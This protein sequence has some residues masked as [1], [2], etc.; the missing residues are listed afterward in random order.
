MGVTAIVDAEDYDRLMEHS[1]WAH[2]TKGKFYAKTEIARRV[3][4]MHR[5]ILGFPDSLIDHIDGNALDNRRDNLRLADHR[6]NGWNS[7]IKGNN[8]SGFKGVNLHRASGLWRA[9]IRVG[10]E[11]M[12]LG[13]FKHPEQAAEAYR[14]AAQ[15][16]HGEFARVS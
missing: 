9:R 4:L 12:N 10:G 8:T 2:S 5:F 16:H 11:H 3:V 14:V 15:E 6:Q 13:Y 7:A 1:W